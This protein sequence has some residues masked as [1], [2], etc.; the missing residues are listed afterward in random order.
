MNEKLG[1]LTVPQLA[2]RAGT[3]MQPESCSSYGSETGMDVHHFKMFKTLHLKEKKCQFFI[4][5]HLNR[6]LAVPARVYRQWRVVIESA[7]HIDRCYLTEAGVRFVKNKG[8]S[9]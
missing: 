4:V 2:P 8:T 6:E 7:H 5:F 3:G 9:G 1:F